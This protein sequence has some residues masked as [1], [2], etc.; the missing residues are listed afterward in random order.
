MKAHAFVLFVIFLSM[1]DCYS[2]T[3]AWIEEK[4]AEEIELPRELDSEA[5]EDSGLPKVFSEVKAC[6]KL[7]RKRKLTC[8]KLS[9]KCNS[10]IE[11]ILGKSKRARKCL[12][13][14]PMSERNTM[15]KH[16]CNKSCNECGK[17]CFR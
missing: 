3:G 13:K 17:L 14:M 15:V 5:C 1:M 12:K 4:D 9:S 8:S 7:K 10:T 2:S 11:S 16:Y 6:R